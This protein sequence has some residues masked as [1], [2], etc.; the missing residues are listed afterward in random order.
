MVKISTADFKRGM[1]I[2]FRGQPYQMI[3]IQFVNPGKG[4]AFLR[5]KLKNVKNGKVLDFTFK[6]GE[7]VEELAVEVNELQ[8]LYKDQSGYI[9]MHPKTYEQFT[10]SLATVADLGKYLK[11]GGIQQILVYNSEAVSIRI[12]AKV[13]LKVIQAAEG[14]AGDTVGSAMKP[15][16]VETGATINVPLF[17]KEGDIIIIRPE[18]GEYLGRESG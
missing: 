4:S 15:V 12:P 17:V 6:S 5:T 14:D 7:S 16:T 18:T 8:Y 1:Y 13:K 2:E 3:D 11:E 10:L 9:F